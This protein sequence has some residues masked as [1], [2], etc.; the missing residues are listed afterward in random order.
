MNWVNW[1]GRVVFIDESKRV[2]RG[3]VLDSTQGDSPSVLLQLDDENKP[4]WRSSRTV[5]PDVFLN[6]SQNNLNLN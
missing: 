1:R 3:T 4:C 2:R 5:F 6:L